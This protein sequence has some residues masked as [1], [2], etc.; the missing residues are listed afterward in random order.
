MQLFKLIVA[1][2]LYAG[3]DRAEDAKFKRSPQKTHSHQRLSLRTLRKAF[4]RVLLL[5]LGEFPRSPHVNAP[6][7]GALAPFARAR[8]DEFA[9]ELSKPG[10]SL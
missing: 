4:H 7:L 3:G 5:V 2:A 9:L 6:R 10:P 8:T 1:L